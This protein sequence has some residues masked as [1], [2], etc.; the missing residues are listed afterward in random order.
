MP[1]LDRLLEHSFFTQSLK[2]TA[3]PSPLLIVQLPRYG[4]QKI[5]PRIVPPLKLNL[6]EVRRLCLGHMPSFEVRWLQ[7]CSHQLSLWSVY[8]ACRDIGVISD[9]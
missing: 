9:V 2:L 5:F 1:G 7:V 4:K 3:V 6:R 8:Q